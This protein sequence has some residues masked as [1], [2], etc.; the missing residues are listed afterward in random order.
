MQTRHGI[1][2]EH[3]GE[4][5]VESS[6]DLGTRIE[7]FLPAILQDMLEALGYTVTTP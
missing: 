4:I 6:P 2:K 7:M 3:G 1:V 5:F